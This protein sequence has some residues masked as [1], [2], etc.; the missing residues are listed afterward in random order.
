VARACFGFDAGELDR[1]QPDFTDLDGLFDDP[2]VT[3]LPLAYDECATV[4][5]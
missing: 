3:L 1:R 5:G 2:F 4:R